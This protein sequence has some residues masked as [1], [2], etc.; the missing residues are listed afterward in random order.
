MPIFSNQLATP[1]QVFEAVGWA[2]NSAEKSAFSDRRI[3]ERTIVYLPVLVQLVDDASQ[4]I[5]EAFPA[6]TRDVSVGGIGLICDRPITGKQM[7]VKFT[8]DGCSDVP[9]LMDIRYCNGVEPYKFVGG[10]FC[11]DWFAEAEE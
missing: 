2:I 8:V 9:M 11:A 7:I 6:V 3:S 4:P 1:E 5:G 10:S